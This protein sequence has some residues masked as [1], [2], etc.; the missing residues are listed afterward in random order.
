MTTP[1][2]I[3]VKSDNYGTYWMEC[4]GIVDYPA[5]ICSR[6]L[7]QLELWFEKFHPHRYFHSVL[8]KTLHEHHDSQGVL[9]PGLR[10]ALFVPTHRVNEAW[11]FNASPYGQRMGGKKRKLPVGHTDKEVIKWQQSLPEGMLTPQWLAGCLTMED[12]LAA[13]RVNHPEPCPHCR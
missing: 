3:D 4:I 8:Q 5:I 9:R 12:L 13:D 6:S 11:D 2:I 7:D 1:I 10:I